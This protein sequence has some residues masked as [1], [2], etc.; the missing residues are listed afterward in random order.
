MPVL[1]AKAP[2]Y[3]KQF[4]VTAAGKTW[5]ALRSAKENLS[6][7]I[8]DKI[9]ILQT[10]LKEMFQDQDLKSVSLSLLKALTILRLFCL[11]HF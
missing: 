11:N 9:K 4:G 5:D 3:E 8:Y 10:S 1:K 2:D 7:A 6:L